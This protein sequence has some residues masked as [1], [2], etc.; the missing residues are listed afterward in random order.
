M[1]AEG[2]ECTLQD[3]CIRWCVTCRVPLLLDL[4]VQW[5]RGN[6]LCFKLVC[7]QAVLKQQHDERH[8]CDN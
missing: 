5:K 1:L 4:I 3:C 7:G 8:I 2:S 6:A